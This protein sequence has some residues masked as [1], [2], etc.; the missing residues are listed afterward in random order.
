M[1]Q[2]IRDYPNVTP[3]ERLMKICC[4]LLHLD[5]QIENEFNS[6]CPKST[7]AVLGIVHAI[8]DDARSTLCVNPKCN[9]ALDA[10]IRNRKYQ[11]KQ[12]LIEPVAQVLYQLGAGDDD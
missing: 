1:S 9:N 6:A 5:K 3:E 12:N 8:T 7:P 4:L 2:A 10:S 11:P